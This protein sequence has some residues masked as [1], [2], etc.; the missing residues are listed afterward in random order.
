MSDDQNLRQTALSALA[1][2]AEGRKGSG[3]SDASEVITAATT[4]LQHVYEPPVDLDYYRPLGPTPLCGIKDT[5]QALQPKWHQVSFR[6]LTEFFLKATVSALPSVMLVFVL[7]VLA[8]FSS[9]LLT[10]VMQ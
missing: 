7:Y 2:I 5:D 6:E 10:N 4:I 3:T 1:A 8:F 9:V